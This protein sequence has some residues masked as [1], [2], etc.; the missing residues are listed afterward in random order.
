MWVSGDASLLAVVG[1]TVS[2]DV[3]VTQSDALS[4]I[5]EKA[6]AIRPS[7]ARTS[8]AVLA[9]TWDAAALFYLDAARPAPRFA[10]RG[11]G[12]RAFAM[13][14]VFSAVLLWLSV[15]SGGHVR[16]AAWCIHE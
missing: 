6:P 11:T 1:T 5:A 4:V 14:T 9:H 7:S 8:A 2:V 15:I 10:R 12:S 16:V 13:V 3:E